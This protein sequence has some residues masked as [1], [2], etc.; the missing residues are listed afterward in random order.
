[1]FSLK[2]VADH[3][4]VP[5]DLGNGQVINFHQYHDFTM[6]EIATWE[7]VRRRVAQ[8]GKQR[9]QANSQQ[10]H[11]QLTKE[12]IAACLEMIRLCL[13]DLP[14]A[15]V[16]TLQPGQLD[17]LAAI[18]IQV[19]SGMYVRGR[20]DE[21]TVKACRDLYPNLP[22]EFWET[23]TREQIKVLMGDDERG[24]SPNG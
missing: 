10:K 8:L 2:N 13:P 5:F 23:V 16:S 18:C 3:E 1:M 22:P 11:E 20:A 17:N 12:N 7:R 15:I 19:A 24:N 6:S 21:A 14:E 4:A 9:E